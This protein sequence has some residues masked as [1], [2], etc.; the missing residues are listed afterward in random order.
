MFG[1]ESR[2]WYLTAFRFSLHHSASGICAIASSIGSGPFSVCQSCGMWL[3]IA[4]SNATGLLPP[5]CTRSGDGWGCGRKALLFSCWQAAQ[6]LTEWDLRFHIAH[7]CPDQVR[8]NTFSGIFGLYCT[9]SNILI[10]MNLLHVHIVLLDWFHNSSL[11]EL[12][13]GGTSYIPYFCRSR[14]ILTWSHM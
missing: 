9:Y 4:R 6:A 2:R 7:A 3:A 10:N 13:L 1:V 8:D 11:V 14:P 12:F 5:L